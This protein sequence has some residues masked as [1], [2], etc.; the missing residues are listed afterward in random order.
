MN[1]QFGISDKSYNLILEAICSFK[2]IEHAEIFGSRAIGNF[3]Q[4]SDIDIA[5]FG[6]HLQEFTA[7]DLSAKLNE[8]APIPYFVDVVAPEFLNNENLKDHI[9]CVGVSFYTKDD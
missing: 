9:E 6:E 5:I 8:S 2:D 3:K 4:G 1:N 7:M